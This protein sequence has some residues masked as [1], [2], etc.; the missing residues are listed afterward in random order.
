MTEKSL[1][2]QIGFQLDHEDGHEKPIAR[3]GHFAVQ[4]GMSALSP[5]ATLNAFIRMSA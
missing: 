1:G 5:K 4:T 2:F 3:F